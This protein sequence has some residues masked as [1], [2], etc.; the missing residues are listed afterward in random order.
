MY[1]AHGRIYSI[2]TEHHMYRGRI[3]RRTV[4]IDGQLSFIVLDPVRIAHACMHAR[5]RGDATPCEIH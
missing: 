3:L 5:S 2:H 4:R 1:S